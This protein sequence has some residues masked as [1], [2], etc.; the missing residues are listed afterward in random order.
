MFEIL[1]NN[2]ENP[3]IHLKTAQPFNSRCSEFAKVGE[4]WLR[5]VRKEGK[6]G[7][8]ELA[9]KIGRWLGQ[10]LRGSSPKQ[11][12]ET[13]KDTPIFQRRKIRGYG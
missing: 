2:L 13:P 12:R 1:K 10:T 7:E 3:L 4:S 5:W 11:E 6:I 8:N 9:I